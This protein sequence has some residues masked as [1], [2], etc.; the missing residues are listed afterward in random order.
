MTKLPP[1][2]Y[3]V[4]RPFD[5][6]FPNGETFLPGTRLRLFYDDGDYVK[7]AVEGYSVPQFTVRTQVF[8]KCTILKE[9]A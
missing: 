3:I 6:R 8:R 7:F 1:G 9:R 5:T 4:R 2:I